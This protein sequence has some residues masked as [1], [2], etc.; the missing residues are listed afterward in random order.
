MEA[1]SVAVVVIVP[2]MLLIT[3]VRVIAPLLMMVVVV[4]ILVVL[5][6]TLVRM[7]PLVILFMLAVTVALAVLLVLMSL[8]RL[9]GLMMAMLKDVMVRMMLETTKFAVEVMVLVLSSA[10]TTA[11]VMTPVLALPST[12]LLT[13]TRER[14]KCMLRRLRR[15]QVSEVYVY[16]LVAALVRVQAAGQ[17]HPL[18]E[19]ASTNAQHSDACSALT[20]LLHACTMIWTFSLAFS[21]SCAHNMNTR[22][23]RKKC[24]SARRR[25][26][27]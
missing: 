18:A 3:L 6:I 11:S 14:F 1:L 19:R 2:V 26:T 5:L 25:L 7:I 20:P 10:L 12:Q 22:H 21:S 16:R 13:P 17:Q 23:N 27:K 15:I 4:V 24:E 8:L 9:L